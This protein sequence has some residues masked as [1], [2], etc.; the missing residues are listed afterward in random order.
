MTAKLSDNA[1][2]LL[3]DSSRADETEIVNRWISENKKFLIEY[4]PECEKGCTLLRKK[5]NNHAN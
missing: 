1:V 5:S 4:T 2:I 3:D